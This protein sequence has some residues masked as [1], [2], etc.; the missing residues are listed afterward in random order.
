[1]RIAIASLLLATGCL[2]LGA[3]DPDAPHGTGTTSPPPTA[4]GAFQVRSEL[5]LTVEAILPE[6]AAGAVQ[7]LRAFSTHPARTLFDLAEDAGVPAVGTIRSALPGLLEDR[8]EGWIDGELA[9][10]TLNGVS[11]PQLAGSIAAIAETALTQF[12]IDS[13]LALGDGTATHTL[14]T[15]DLAPA[16]LDVRYALAPLP[17]QIVTATAASSTRHAT[18]EVGD[19]GYALAYGEYAWRAVDDT[20]RAQHGLGIRDALGAAVGCPALASKIASTCYLGYCVGHEAELTQI[21]ER[22]LDEVVERARAKVVA[23]RF[24]ALRF[25]AGTATLVDDDRDGQADR[26]I[27]GVWTAQINAGM[28][29]RHAPATFT[30]TR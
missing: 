16:G 17:A 10:L 25:A 8:L 23:M 3:P 18:L 21:C 22:G 5:D 11:V 2:T 27:G 26:L 9:K 30:A 12:A 7:T 19:H 14:T 6:R 20:L 24:D 4:S 29:L 13:E 28:G 15:L 1:M